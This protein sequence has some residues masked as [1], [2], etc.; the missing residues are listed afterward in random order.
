MSLYCNDEEYLSNTNSLYIDP[1][2][3][4][5]S[6]A[7][8]FVGSTGTKRRWS[9]ADVINRIGVTMKMR[10]QAIA[11]AVLSLSAER[12]RGTRIDSDGA[13]GCRSP[14]SCSALPQRRHRR[15]CTA[16]IGLYLP[17]SHGRSGRADQ[18][19]RSCNRREG[20][21]WPRKDSSRAR[22][23]FLGARTISLPWCSSSLPCR[24]SNQ[25][26]SGG[27][28]QRVLRKRIQLEA[29]RQ[30]LLRQ[31][32]RRHVRADRHPTRPQRA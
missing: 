8:P 15:N 27:N 2:L 4:S 21:L 19:K 17:I 26:Q 12:Q 9:S 24:P 29:W 30:R 3:N 5:Y 1:D 11:A 25:R 10:K 31:S 23:N 14:A 20:G 32:G 13:G 28:A 6:S 16:S 18:R 22:L 7:P